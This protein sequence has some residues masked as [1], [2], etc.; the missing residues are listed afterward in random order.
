MY[1]YKFI[2][3]KKRRNFN[4]LD[5][6]ILLIVF[7]TLLSMELVHSGQ[8]YYLYKKAGFIQEIFF[9]TEIKFTSYINMKLLINLKVS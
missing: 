9:T 6:N 1:L 3:A 7:Y 4:N 8:I 5:I 2:S